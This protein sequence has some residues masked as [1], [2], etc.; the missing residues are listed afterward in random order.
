MIEHIYVTKDET[1]V[2]RCERPG[3]MTTARRQFNIDTHIHEAESRAQ[4]E[5]EEARNRKMDENMTNA[6]RHRDEPD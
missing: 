4:D 1:L 3:S 5:S 6:L 2:L